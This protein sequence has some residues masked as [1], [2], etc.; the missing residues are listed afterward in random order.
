MN[1][2]NLLATRWFSSSSDRD[3]PSEKPGSFESTWNIAIKTPGKQVQTILARI[4]RFLSFH[5]SQGLEYIQSVC[6]NTM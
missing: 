6:N 1:D 3:F 2:R 4:L 5:G